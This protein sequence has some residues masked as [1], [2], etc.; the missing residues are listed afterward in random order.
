MTK[1]LYY[2]STDFIM[3]LPNSCSLKMGD[4]GCEIPP[5]YVVS[6]N[7][8]NEEYM[9]GV[10]C[11]EHMG[12]IEKRLGGAQQRHSKYRSPYRPCDSKRHERHRRERHDKTEHEA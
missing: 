7:T 9:I 4:N 5:S 3:L 10:V 12:E 6:I 2:F 8:Q 1:F 11:K